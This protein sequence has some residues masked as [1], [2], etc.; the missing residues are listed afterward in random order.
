MKTIA[1]ACCLLLSGNLWAEDFET[2]F[3]NGNYAK[4]IEELNQNLSTSDRFYH[5]AVCYARLQ[6]FDKAIINFEKAIEEK[7]EKKDLYYEYGQAL[8]ASNELKKSR[9]AFVHSAQSKFNPAQS[10]YYVGHISQILEEFNV[11]SVAYNKIISSY[12]SEIKLKQIAQFQVAEIKLLTLKDKTAEHVDK[13]ILPLLKTALATDP[14]SST[15][16]DIDKRY[17]ELLIEYKLDPDLLDNGK[18][19]PSRRWEASI[20]QK[21]KFDDNVTLSNYEN[22]I[23][24]TKK[25][26]FIFDTEV[27]SKYTFLSNKNILISPEAR[28]TFTQYG[29]RTSSEVFQNDAYILNLNLKN[30]YEATLFNKPA[31]TIFDIEYSKTAKDTNKRHSRDPYSSSLNFTIGESFSYFVSG[32]TSIKFKRKE[33]KGADVSINNTTYE[34]SADQTVALSN[35]NL[36]I[37]VIDASQIDNYNNVSMSTNTYLMRVDYII[38]E[39]FIHHTLDIAVGETVT[40]TKLQ[41]STRGTETS[42]NPSLDLSRDLSPN[43][44]ISV[45]YDF[46]DNS[47]KSTDYTYQKH[48]ISMELKYVF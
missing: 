32:D 24:Q 13:E 8:Y 48:V 4:A 29:D 34:F 42:L 31:S 1:L 35:Q 2:F 14:Q 16:K 46:T 12:P 33:Y 9:E 40:D 36:L 15:A 10:L 22:N 7:S 26:S 47:S 37:L 28:F 3:S 5:L 11:S 25:E 23:T 17:H 41:K 18:R 39:I 20:S 19:I 21:T 38:P 30:K 27:Y 43:T 44:K 6:E 45:N